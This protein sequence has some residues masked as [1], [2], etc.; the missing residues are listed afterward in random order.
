MNEEVQDN[1]D[2]RDRGGADELSVAEEGGGTMVVAVEEGQRLL[3]EEQ[4]DSVKEL[5]VLG[6]VV[7]LLRLL[8]WVACE[9]LLVTH[10]VQNDK[11]LG[12]ATLGVTD[13]MEDTAANNGGKK[14]LNEESQKRTTDQ[15]QVEV[16]DKEE[17][18]EL[19]RLAV[20]HPLATTEND[21]VVDDDEDGSRLHGRHGSLERHKLEVIGGV[22]DDS[23][24]SLVKDGP[25]MNTK[26]AVDGRQRQLLVEGSGRRRHDGRIVG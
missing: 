6:E 7:E 26:G 5:E 1:G 18:L 14:L 23:G 16:V 20:A 25:Q 12:P 17:T 22:A 13:G 2:P 10:V 11:G 19:E 4:E 15:S 8:A 21:A 24:E 9:I 3:L